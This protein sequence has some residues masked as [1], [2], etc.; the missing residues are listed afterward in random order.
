[1]TTY[2]YNH[3]LHDALPILLRQNKVVCHSAPPPILLIRNPLHRS[4][5]IPSS[6]HAHTKQLHSRDTEPSAPPQHRRKADVRH[7]KAHSRHG[8]ACENG[9]K[10]EN[11]FPQDL[12]VVCIPLSQGSFQ[13]LNVRLLGGFVELRFNLLDI[14]FHRHLS[15]LKS[16]HPLLKFHPHHPAARSITAPRARHHGHKVK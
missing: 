11:E 7:T 12:G 10:N 6:G 5:D 8:N 16:G 13:P 9:N 3:S 15:F 2:L 4:G 14:P 1:A